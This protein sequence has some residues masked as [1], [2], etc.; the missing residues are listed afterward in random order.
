MELRHQALEDERRRRVQLERQLQDEAMRRQRLIEK[1]V[2]M[3]E[4]QFAQVRE[5]Q[6][7]G[8][9]GGQG[10]PPL[11]LLEEGSGRGGWITAQGVSCWAQGPPLQSGFPAFSVSVWD[12]WASLPAPPPQGLCG[13]GASFLSEQ[14]VGGA[15]LRQRRQP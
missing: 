15:E 12:G 3:R 2:K 5:G 4:K 14:Q 13:G 10:A 1:E 11:V 8:R 9:G 6:S 7:S